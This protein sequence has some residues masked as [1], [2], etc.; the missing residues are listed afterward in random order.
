MDNVQKHSTFI[1]VSFSQNF[2]LIK[3]W[4]V[5]KNV[6]EFRSNKENY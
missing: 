3:F 1:N 6:C 4:H 5:Q 2:V